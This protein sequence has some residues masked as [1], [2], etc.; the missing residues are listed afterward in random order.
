MAQKE[1]W[2]DVPNF[3]GYYQAS[4]LGRVRSLDRIV[5]DSRGGERFYKGRVLAGYINKTTGYRQASLN[6]N[7]ERIT[8]RA[9][10]IVAITYL[11]H[12]PDGF[13]KVIDHING[14]KLD[15]RVENLQ[16]VTHR[17]NS[18]TCFRKDR[19]NLSSKYVGVSWNKRDKKWQAHIKYEGELIYL[20]LFNTELEASENYQ[21]SLSEIN[22]GVFNPEEYKP[23]FASKY[24]GV[25]FHKASNRW[26]SQVRVNGK[27]KYLGK[28]KTELEAH[29][30]YQKALTN[31]L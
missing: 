22:N 23:N 2:K 11:G 18:T 16:I 1:I 21:K 12:K 15:D 27:Q 7:G 17:E 26:T 30:A 20:G 5:V 29:H 6:I 28:F 24:K 14:N 9:S 3:E 4:N 8:L 19:K 10:Q 25:Y 13:N 31:Q